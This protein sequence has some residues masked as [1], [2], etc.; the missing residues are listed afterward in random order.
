MAMRAAAPGVGSPLAVF[1]DS[2]KVH[3]GV[4]FLNPEMTTCRQEVKDN[5]DVFALLLLVG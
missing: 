5:L 2:L 1:G 4:Y 3:V